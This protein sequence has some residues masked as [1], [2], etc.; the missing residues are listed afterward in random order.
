MIGQPP[1]VSIVIPTYNRAKYVLK[2]VDSV[3]NQT[4]TDY[5]IIVVD[6]GST[7]STKENLSQYWEQIKYVYQNNSGVSAARNTGIAVSRGRWVAFL[8]S[9]D[10]W[11]EEY[12]EVQIRYLTKTS[13]LCMQSTDSSFNDLNGEVKTCFDISGARAVF[14]GNEYVILDNPFNFVIR[15]W[16]FS[17]GST[18]CL[19][20][21]IIKAGLF[22]ATL[23]F[24]ED[25]DFM[26]RASLQGGVG[27]INRGLVRRYRRGE[28]TECLTHQMKMD[29]IGSIE[30]ELYV[31][32]KLNTLGALK[33]RERK[34]L[35]RGVSERKRMIGN[36]LAE[37]GDNKGAR[38]WYKSAIVSDPSIRS[39]GRYL[40]SYV[41]VYGQTR[42]TVLT[43]TKPNARA[44]K[45]L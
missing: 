42:W 34:A 31:Y 5:E 36:I 32:E 7:D 44:T 23:N 35:N 43:K 15:H 1:L 40:L 21:A 10:E 4:F 37:M 8:D 22:D 45:E 18:I 41:G 12:L 14:K 29:P 13:G 3:L 9:D 39:F 25:L 19:R 20:D 33:Y 6:D 26:A 30:K 24:A 27:L 16:G 17:I 11:D 28:A 2:A 38:G